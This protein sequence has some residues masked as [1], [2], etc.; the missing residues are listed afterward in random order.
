M[1]G[2]AQRR[3]FMALAQAQPDP[4]PGP[5]IV[6]GFLSETRGLS[7]AARLTLAGLR[8]AGFAPIEHDLR[9]L[10]AAGPGHKARLPAEPPG[11]V[12]ISHV[13]APE[14]LQALGYLDPS[15]WLDRYRIGYW[16]YELQ[17]V[18]DS[19]VRVSRAFHEIWTPSQ[20]VADAL[21]AAGVRVPVR[22]MPHPVA[23][24]GLKAV[25]DRAAFKIPPNDFTVL[26][27]GDLTSSAA[28]KNIVGAIAIYKRA[29]PEP[30]RQRLVLKVQATDPHPSMQAE[31]EKAA[32]GRPDISWRSE[33]FSIEDTLKL[34]A[35]CDVL[36]SPHRSEGYGLPLAE[37]FLLGVPALATGWSGNMDFMG[38]IPELLIRHDPVVVQDPY[39]IYRMP[40]QTWAEPDVAD[41]AKKLRALA[42]SSELRIKLAAQG[43]A[44]VEAQAAFWSRA[45]LEKTALGRLVK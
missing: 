6:S 11:G 44:G 41:A 24:A 32:G 39:G 23:L 22:V 8:S 29:F 26:A 45:E 35:S 4:I 38:G 14:V 33:S 3:V 13:N 1:A 2:V 27:M 15:S 10:L 12:W 43:R 19:W 40:G 28:R 42:G 20:F 17:R 18:P 21:L 7:Q 30:G 16:V 31:I 25:P 9:V 34:I 36:L 37:A 5:L